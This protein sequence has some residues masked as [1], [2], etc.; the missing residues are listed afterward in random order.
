VGPVA[1][2][3]TLLNLGLLIAAI[4]AASGAPPM[5]LALGRLAEL[6]AVV[7]IAANAWPRIKPFGAG[8][9]E[10]SEAGGS[11]PESNQIGL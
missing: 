5:V 4:G 3:F 11:I 9:G 2:A 10:V 6:A 7:A 8:R 1:A